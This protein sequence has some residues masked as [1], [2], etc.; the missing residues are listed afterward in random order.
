MIQTFSVR[1]VVSVV[2]RTWENIYPT[3]SSSLGSTL[4][5]IK[6]AT[7]DPLYSHT[8]IVA[9]VLFPRWYKRLV[10]VELYQWLI[11]LERIFIP[12]LALRWVRHSYL[13]KRL[14]TIPYT[15]G[16]SRTRARLDLPSLAGR[17]CGLGQIERD[18]ARAILLLFI[19]GSAS[20]SRVVLARESGCRSLTSRQWGP[21][22]DI[23]VGWL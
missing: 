23:N 12:P 17:W 2:D 3:F 20:P 6:K 21:P 19:P 11:E 16:I 8:R 1:R 10:C 15:C 4:L 7:H 22:C 9:L 18:L 5:L 13:S 14:H